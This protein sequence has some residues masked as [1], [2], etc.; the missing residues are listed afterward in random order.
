MKGLRPSFLIS[1]LMIGIYIHI[2]ERGIKGVRLIN[3]LP[4]IKGK[5]IKGIGLLKRGFASLFCPFSAPAL[6]S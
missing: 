2:M 4:L 5:G 1:S 6:P 3:N